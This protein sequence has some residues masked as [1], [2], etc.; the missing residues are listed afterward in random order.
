MHNL[1][2]GHVSM[3]SYLICDIIDKRL[4]LDVSS[5]TFDIDPVFDL[6]EAEA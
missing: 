3:G 6:R 2:N 1:S 5:I 4:K